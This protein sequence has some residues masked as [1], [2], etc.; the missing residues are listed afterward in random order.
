VAG[1]KNAYKITVSN[2]TVDGARNSPLTRAIPVNERKIK[3]ENEQWQA[4]RQELRMEKN[5]PGG[6]D[7]IEAKIT[8]LIGAVLIVQS[9]AQQLRRWLSQVLR[10]GS[11]TPEMVAYMQSA[12]L[13]MESHT[14]NM[15]A[16]MRT[17]ISIWTDL[18]KISPGNDLLEQM[19]LPYING[20]APLPGM[21]LPDAE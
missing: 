20:D 3:M 5:N 6:A 17:L 12:L 16:Q 18:Q 2:K 9:Y 11:A 1:S 7:P 8:S 15:C 4:K 21:N 14:Q 13:G 10:S 19:E